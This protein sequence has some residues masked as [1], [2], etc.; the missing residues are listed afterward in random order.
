MSKRPEK[1]SLDHLVDFH[2]ELDY[3][4]E[5]YKSVNRTPEMPVKAL[6]AQFSQM[7]RQIEFEL[8]DHIVSHI[9]TIS[10]MDCVRQK[11]ILKMLKGDISVSDDRFENLMQIAEATNLSP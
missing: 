7:S 5:R 8:L 4:V 2:Q 1:P 10:D 11:F 6:A 9:K 3:A